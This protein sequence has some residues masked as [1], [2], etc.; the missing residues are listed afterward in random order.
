MSVISS[1]KKYI[2][3]QTLTT[4]FHIYIAILENIQDVETIFLYKTICILSKTITYVFNTY[5]VL[6]NI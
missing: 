3:E 6:K 1:C 4:N 5:T 2:I